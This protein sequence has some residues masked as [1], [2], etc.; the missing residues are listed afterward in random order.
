MKSKYLEFVQVPFKGKTKRYNVVSKTS[1]EVCKICKGSGDSFHKVS[2]EQDLSY[3]CPI[4][5]GKGK[6]PIILGIISWYPQWRRY[7]FS[8]AF[9]TVWDSG[10]LQA[11][12]IFLNVLMDARIK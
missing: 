4:C 11:I 2:T 7:T 3:P 8:P 1:F 10:C 12:E 9:P 5:N 6:I